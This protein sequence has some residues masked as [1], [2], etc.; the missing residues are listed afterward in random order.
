MAVAE[1]L[2]ALFIAMSVFMVKLEMIGEAVSALCALPAVCFDH[3]RAN[4]HPIA[5]LL[6]MGRGRMRL[7]P[8]CTHG[9]FPYAA[10]CSCSI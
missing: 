8:R 7:L 5:L 6:F 10:F 4:S 2:I 3:G 1:Y 9:C